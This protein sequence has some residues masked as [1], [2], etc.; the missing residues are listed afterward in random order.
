[1]LNPATRSIGVICCFS[2]SLS[3]FP[4]L[5]V[6]ILLDQNPGKGS[7]AS[8]HVCPCHPAR[9]CHPAL[10]LCTFVCLKTQDSCTGACL[11]TSS[12]G[13]ATG[14]HPEHRGSVEGPKLVGSWPLAHSKP[15]LSALST[16]G[17]VSNLKM[18]CPKIR[19]GSCHSSLLF[20]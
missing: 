2:C 3:S 18:G 5:S 20:L 16:T 11:V 6:L 4:G 8:F 13:Y 7:R 1:M 17:W 12:L 14:F 10:A 15:P 9:P 19:L